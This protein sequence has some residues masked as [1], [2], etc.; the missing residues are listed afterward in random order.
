MNKLIT[1]IIG[2]ESDHYRG[3]V[4][5]TVASLHSLLFEESF[6]FTTIS[7]REARILFI[8]AEFF[9]GGLSYK[10]IKQ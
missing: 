3:R 4:R 1:I 10:F 8:G 6:L 5:G 9:S 2:R 7:L